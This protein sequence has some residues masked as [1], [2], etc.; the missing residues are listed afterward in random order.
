MFGIDLNSPRI[1]IPPS[2]KKI[3]DISCSGGNGYDG[4]IIATNDDP[5]LQS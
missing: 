4:G 2:L 3:L 1:Q 5:C